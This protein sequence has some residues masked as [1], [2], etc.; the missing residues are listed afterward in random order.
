MSE[1]PPRDHDDIAHIAAALAPDFIDLVDLETVHLV[2]SESYARISEGA[3]IRTFV[4]VLA[5]RDARE[6]LRAVA[7]RTPPS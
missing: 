5:Q 1:R 2:A 6:R 3:R 4:G 7:A